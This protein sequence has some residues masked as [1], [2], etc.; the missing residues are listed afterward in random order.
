MIDWFNPLSEKLPHGDDFRVSP[1]I[2]HLLFDLTK[3][4][5]E[6]NGPRFRPFS[7]RFLE[8]SINHTH[9]RIVRYESNKLIKSKLT[10]RQSINQSNPK[11]YNASL[12][13]IDWFNPLSEK[14]PHGDDFRVSPFIPHLLF[15]LTKSIKERNGPRFRPFSERFLEQSIIRTHQQIVRYESN[16]LIKSKITFRQSI[17]QTKKF[18]MKVYAWL[19]DLVHCRKNCP[20]E[21]ISGWVQKATEHCGTI[22]LIE[23]RATSIQTET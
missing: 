22:Q 11:A 5:K 7:E 10:Y 13:L 23:G 4:I 9:Q 12:R 15:D 18:T 17:N 6:R 3:S 20:T 8:Q 16:K 14:L 21:M 1:F 2:P 19:I